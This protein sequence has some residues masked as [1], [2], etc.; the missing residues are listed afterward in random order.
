MQFWWL[1]S[2]LGRNARVAIDASRDSRGRCSFFD[3]MFV[4]HETFS[5]F[6]AFSPTRIDEAR[7][8]IHRRSIRIPRRSRPWASCSVFRKRFRCTVA[9]CPSGEHADVP[10]SGP[11]LSLAELCP[12]VT[13]TRTRIDTY[14]Y[15][16]EGLV[17]TEIR[18]RVSISRT[19]KTSTIVYRVKC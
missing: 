6:F 4:G 8:G 14:T 2:L 1:I 11:I 17:R 5:R 10:L 12:P 9:Q 7:L 19:Y 16:A 3:S 18:E 13:H 15:Q